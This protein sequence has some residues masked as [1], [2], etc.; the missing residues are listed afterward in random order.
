MRGSKAAKI[1]NELQ[2]LSMKIFLFLRDSISTFGKNL[3][4]AKIKCIENQCIKKVKSVGI[5]F[6]TIDTSVRF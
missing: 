2:I 6:E 1:K 3:R 4:H 5:E